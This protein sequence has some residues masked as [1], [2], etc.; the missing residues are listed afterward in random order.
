M[1]YDVGG[2]ASCGARTIL[3]DLDDEYGQTAKRRFG[4]DARM[5][6]WST[7]PPEEIVRRRAMNDAAETMVNKRVSRLSMLADAIDEILKED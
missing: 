4:P 7:N 1:A 2:S 6:S 5:P 3:L